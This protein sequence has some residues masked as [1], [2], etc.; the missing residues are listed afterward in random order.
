MTGATAGLWGG[1]CMGMGFRASAVAVA[2]AVTMSGCGSG[3]P[4]VDEAFAQ[5]MQRPDVEQAVASYEEMSAKVRERLTSE[6][7]R[8]WE[9]VSEGGASGCGSE[10][11]GLTGDVDIRHLPRW[12]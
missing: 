4:N 5:L 9:Q 11:P 8:A 12:S 7:G 6:L 10:F 2:L 3:G 1:R